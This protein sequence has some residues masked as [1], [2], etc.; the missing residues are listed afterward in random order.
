NCNVHRECNVKWVRDICVV[1]NIWRFTMRTIRYLCLCMVGLLS[2]CAA[3]PQVS[4]RQLPLRRVVVYRN[5][6]GYY[7]RAGRVHRNGLQFDV[8]SAR[9]GDFLATLAIME[10]GPSSVR[11]ASFPIKMDGP[12]HKPN[13]VATVTLELDGRDHDLQVGY[14]AETPV[15]RP[16]YRL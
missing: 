12:E 16:S 8:R 6:V 9:V 11:A 7:E 13:G 3:G 5:G 2:G 1:A 15:W 14:V 10:R 4:A